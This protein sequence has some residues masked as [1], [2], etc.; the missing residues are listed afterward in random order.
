MTRR[1]KVEQPT[2]AECGDPVRAIEGKVLL[3]GNAPA[4]R[5]VERPVGCA[6]GD[7]LM[8]KNVKGA[9]EE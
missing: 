3:R 7:P 4:Y 1:K 8:L 9:P 6:L 5:H 2:C